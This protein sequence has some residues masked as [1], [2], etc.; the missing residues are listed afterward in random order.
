MVKERGETPFLLSLR[1]LPA[2]ER[3]V[4]VSPSLPLYACI[5]L[6]YSVIIHLR[7]VF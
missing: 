4:A 7:L 5:E 2:L 3:I 1:D 6:E